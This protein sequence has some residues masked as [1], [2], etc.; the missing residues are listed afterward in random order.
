MQLVVLSVEPTKTLKVPPASVKAPD[1]KSPFVAADTVCAEFVKKA[2]TASEPDLIPK[3]VTESV[4][5]I[6]PVVPPSL[7]FTC[8][9]TVS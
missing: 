7:T 5:L 9:S 2:V 4:A 8:T 3:I 6:V 1:A